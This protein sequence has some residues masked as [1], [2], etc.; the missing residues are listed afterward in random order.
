MAKAQSKK[1]SK[2]SQEPK[3]SKKS[4]APESSLAAQPWAMA[5][6]SR[7]RAR[8]GLLGFIFGAV[9]AWQAH[10]DLAMIGIWAIVAGIVC[11]LLGWWIGIIIWEAAVPAEAIG[12]QREVFEEWQAKID[13]R[14]K[15]SGE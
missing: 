5:S 14:R 1:P 11:R 15:Q 7:Y 2:D 3:T 12:R 13:E 6:I 10:S 4:D 9:V 8:G